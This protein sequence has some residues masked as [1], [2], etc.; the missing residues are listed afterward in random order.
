LAQ[1]RRKISNATFKHL[2][3]KKAIEKARAKGEFIE[4][5]E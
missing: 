5:S 3:L 1:E 4:D 2:K